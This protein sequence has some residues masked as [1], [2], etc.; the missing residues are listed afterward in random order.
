MAHNLKLT[1]RADGTEFTHFL[2]D[3]TIQG[4]AWHDGREVKAGGT[5]NTSTRSGGPFMIEEGL[6][7][8]EGDFEAVSEPIFRDD[9]TE[10]QGYQE[11]RHPDGF[12]YQ[13]ATDT[14]EIVQYATLA[15]AL[16]KAMGETAKKPKGSSIGLIGNDA[17]RF[18]VC[19]ITDEARVGAGSVKNF[20]TFEGGHYDKSIVF[21]SSRIFT[22]C[23]NTLDMGTALADKQGTA[24]RIPH[25][26]GANEL[27]KLM[28]A[29]IALTQT[30]D[31]R[32]LEAYQ[33]M[34][35]KTVGRE[36]VTAFVETLFPW[37]KEDGPTPEA[38]Y[39][40][41]ITVEQAFRHEQIRGLP[42][43]SDR[44]S[45]FG[46]LNAAT[47]YVDKVQA[48]GDWARSSFS[49]ACNETRRKAFDLALALVKV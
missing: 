46:L 11:I 48:K 45:A 9:G 4:P 29:K 33:A 35:E 13:V 38:T 27:V 22:V 47:F 39:D 1:K 15:K 43:G 37:D 5:G 23:E 19:S 36:Q 6:E 26:T 2:Y 25:K 42:T 28:A 12:T 40:K 34:V 49:P 30:V 31:K 3:E 32:V 8:I 17:G 18:F 14:Y 44:K 7:R 41:R 10:I 20:L 16:S 24:F 21:Y